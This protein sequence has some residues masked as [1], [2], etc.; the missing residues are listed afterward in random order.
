MKKLLIGLVLLSFSG[1][2]VAQSWRQGESFEQYQDRQ[3]R[4]HHYWQQD[5][6][7]Q[8]WQQ[9]QY[10]RPTYNPYAEMARQSGKQ[11]GE[12]IGNAFKAFGSQ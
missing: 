3:Q 10:Q 4:Q 6:M 7:Y 9:Q 5:Q 11:V 1:I 8:H 12:G 2:T